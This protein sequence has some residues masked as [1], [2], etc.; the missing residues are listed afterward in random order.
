MGVCR[1][2]LKPRMDMGRSLGKVAAACQPYS[3]NPTVR[4]EKGA[5]GIVGHGGTRNQPHNR[6]GA[7]RKLSTYSQARRI[8]TRPSGHWTKTELKRK[9]D[10]LPLASKSRHVDAERHG[11]HLHIERGNGK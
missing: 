1:R 5:C 11:L 7:C 8:S 4:D 2:V 10:N 6:K 9:G 3:E